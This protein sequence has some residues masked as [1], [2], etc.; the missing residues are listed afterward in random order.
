MQFYRARGNRHGWQLGLQKQSSLGCRC[1]P[2]HVNTA[3]HFLL[4]SASRC[5][6]EKAVALQ[7]VRSK[8][9]RLD[10]HQA[11]QAISGG[12]FNCVARIKGGCSTQGVKMH[13][14]LVEGKNIWTI[15]HAGSGAGRE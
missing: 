7:C 10:L 9:H 12:L 5:N 8:V 2:P 4:P 6:T 11:R 3:L 1:P 14:G 13:M 15:A